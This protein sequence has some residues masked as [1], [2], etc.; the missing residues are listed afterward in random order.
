MSTRVE[1]AWSLVVKVLRVYLRV[2]NTLL[3]YSDSS[4]MKSVCVS[5]GVMAVPRNLKNDFPV[6]FL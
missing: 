2:S 5:Q 1:W 6:R 3:P 4:S